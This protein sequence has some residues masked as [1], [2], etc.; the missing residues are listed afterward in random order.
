VRRCLNALPG[1]VGV[2]VAVMGVAV[3]VLLLQR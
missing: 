2:T 3:R 1:E